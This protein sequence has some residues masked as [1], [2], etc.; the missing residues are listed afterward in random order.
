MF[1]LKNIFNGRDSTECIIKIH[2]R[3]EEV[4][5]KD[6]DLE[7]PLQRTYCDGHRL[8]CADT[9]RDIDG[10]PIPLRKRIQIIN[11]LCAYFQSKSN[12]NVFVLDEADKDRKDIISHI[13]KLSKKGHKVSIESDSAEIREQFEDEMHIGILNSGKKLSI[14]GHEINSVEEYMKW[15]ENA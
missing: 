3:G 12:E 9:E 1:G 7:L 11:N 8:Y 6:S 10:S 14:N 13:E 2:G 15:K 4:S 5:Y